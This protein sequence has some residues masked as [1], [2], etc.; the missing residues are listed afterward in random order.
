MYQLNNT[1]VEDKLVKKPSKIK[2]LIHIQLLDK[3]SFSPVKIRI[4]INVTKFGNVGYRF[5][6][7]ILKVVVLMKDE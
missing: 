6:K 2:K 5:Q 1:R 3:F 7:N 4:P